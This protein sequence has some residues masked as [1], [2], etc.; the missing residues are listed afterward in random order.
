M[1][2][3]YTIEQIVENDAG[4]IFYDAAFKCWKSIYRNIVGASVLDIGCGGGVAMA[5]T[6]LFNPALRV[7]GFEGSMAG[8]NVWEMRGLTVTHGDI[9]HLPFPEK[10]FDTVYTSHVLEHLEDPLK[11]IREAAR[12]ASHR[13]IHIVPDGD[14]GA[15]NFGSPHLHIFNRKN[16]RKLFDS[17]SLRIVQYGSIVDPHMNSLII[18]SDR[19]V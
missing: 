9:Y 14:V 17:E 8:K 2:T 12:V 5:L 10:S 1:S 6:K 16:F 15:K 3:E 7:E 18:V 19:G 13:T 4:W 11:A